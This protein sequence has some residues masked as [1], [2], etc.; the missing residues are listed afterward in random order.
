MTDPIHE[1]YDAAHPDTTTGPRWTVPVRLEFN[2]TATGPTPEAAAQNVVDEFEDEFDDL[3]EGV[4]R[5]DISLTTG[6]PE[7]TGNYRD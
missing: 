2:V 7:K 4:Q 5:D 6:I 1:A 3:L